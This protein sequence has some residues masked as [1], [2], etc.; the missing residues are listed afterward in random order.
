MTFYAHR[1]GLHGLRLDRLDRLRETVSQP[2]LRCRPLWHLS[3]SLHQTL[4]PRK[5]KERNGQGTTGSTGFCGKWFLFPIRSVCFFGGASW[6]H[7]SNQAEVNKEVGHINL[8]EPLLAENCPTSSYENAPGKLLPWQQ[9]LVV[10]PGQ[11]HNKLG[12]HVAWLRNQKIPLHCRVSVSIFSWTVWMQVPNFQ[13]CPSREMDLQQPLLV[14]AHKAS[15]P[16]GPASQLQQRLSIW[17]MC[18]WHCILI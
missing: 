18:K 6:P 5:Q 15:A 12:K 16:A 14:W 17:A 11:T 1:W 7:P 8:A 9:Q 4:L 2:A 3:W 10:L 13:P